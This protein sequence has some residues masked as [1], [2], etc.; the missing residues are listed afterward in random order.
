[1]A[2]RIPGAE[3]VAA[4]N[5]ADLPAP[6]R[7]AVVDYLLRWQQ[8]DAAQNCLGQLL[9]SHGHLV[10][11]YDD[12]ARLHLAQGKADLAVEMMRRRHAIGSSTSSRA[13]EARAHLASGDLSSAQGIAD[14]LRHDK[15]ELLLTWSLQ[16]DIRLA[17][18]DL[19]GA[20]EAWRHREALR[21]GAAANAHGLAHVWQAR[22][23]LDKALLWARTALARTV[24]DE[25]EPPVDLLRLLERLFRDTGQE[26]QAAEIAARLRLHQREEWEAIEQKLGLQ[27]AGLAG[28][29]TK[30]SERPPIDSPIRPTPLVPAQQ[31]DPQAE[32]IVT[33]TLGLSSPE[34][35][36]LEKALRQHFGHQAF[37]PGQ[38]DVVGGLLRGESV[39][40]VM[41]TGAGK[42][43]CYQLAALLLPGTTLVIS[44]LIALMKDQIDGLPPS[45]AALTTTLNST[46]EGAEL[47]ARLARAAEG[48]YKMLYAAPER[49]RQRPFLHALKR[50]G[51]SLLVVDE[52][53]C[54]SLWGHDFRPDYMFIAK[55]WQALGRPPLLAMTATATPRVRDDVQTALTRTRLVATDVHRPNLFLEAYAFAKDSQKQRALLSLCQE[56]QGSGIVYATSRLKCE[57]LAEMLRSHGIGAIHY[58]A[59]ISDRGEAQDRFMSDQAR[60]VVATI[61]FGMGIDKADVRFVIHYSPP[62]TLENYFQEAGRAGRDGQT[63][64]C[65]L[66]YTPS[67]KARLT[68]FLRQD[69]LHL[70]FLRQTYAAVKRRV[71]GKTPDL[72][73]MGD[74]ERDLGADGTRLRV[75]IHFLE[76]AG[77]VWRGFDLPRAA[78]LTLTQVPDDGDPEFARFVRAG[79]LRPGETVSRSL[80]K[81]SREAGLDARTI[82]AQVLAWQ[83]AGWLRYR[84]IGRDMLL[85]L[86][87]PPPDSEQRVAAMLA[88]YRSGQDRRITEMIAYAKTRNCRHGHISSY[89]GGRRIERCQACDNCERER[90]ARAHSRQPT[91]EASPA[92]STVE[93]LGVVQPTPQAHGQAQLVS[94]TSVSQII[95]QAVATVPL[96][97]GR[98]GLARALAGAASSTIRPKRF[99]LFGALSSMTQRSIGEHIARLE[100]EGLLQPF[101][102]GRY[103]LLELTEVGKLHLETLETTASADPTLSD[104]EQIPEGDGA[105]V[106]STVALYERLRVWQVQQAKAAGLPPFF[107]LQDATLREIAARCPSAL[108][109]L[110]SIKGIGR[111]KLEQYG[112]AIL[113][114]VASHHDTSTRQRSNDA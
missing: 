26:A 112:P 61:A 31:L 1:M 11:V 55:A 80:L 48:G 65:I 92:R 49:L 79:H 73:S 12:L 5:V 58:H 44:P 81:L 88:D 66:F 76:T 75:A 102:K 106:E 52:G 70:E 41:P 98:K 51:V 45:V 78:T 4:T 39:L 91:Q 8:Y 59:G 72:V 32:A 10:S 89:F 110:L 2:D 50:A 56:I 37:R 97:L 19:D 108:S 107:V 62:K 96:P 64:R 25:R 57:E 84:G 67:D 22:G 7:K 83:D 34:R 95:L 104:Y 38:A 43:L 100:D 47:E 99:P 36:K 68:R 9:Q 15:P 113:E 16:A 24:G 27:Q 101:E 35:Q 28:K 54:V 90:N 87:E 60:V 109:E 40:A 69:A 71:G 82:E 23:D 93:K 33:G 13:L 77:L 63:A 111:R 74:L 114:I 86:P 46:L 105:T 103:R 30:P 85:A 6:I 20:E 53:H 17:M 18:G 42:S 3:Q 29:P 94:Q 21:R 14:Q